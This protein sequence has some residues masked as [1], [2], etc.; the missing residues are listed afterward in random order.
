MMATL[1]IWIRIWPN[2]VDPCV[3]GSETLMNRIYIA[4][5]I[6]TTSLEFRNLF[7]KQF[8]NIFAHPANGTRILLSAHICLYWPKILGDL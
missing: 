6:L 7:Y 4:S 5:G 2:D 3:S 8:C 1:A